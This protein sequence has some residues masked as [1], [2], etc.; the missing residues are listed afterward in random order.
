[1]ISKF[2]RCALLVR[3]LLLSRGGTHSNRRKTMIVRER[4]TKDPITI[5]PDET[6]A[7][8]QAKMES[9]GFRQ[10][11]VIRDDKLV[12]ILTDRDIRQHERQMRITKVRE[13][14]GQDVITVPPKAPLEEAARILLEH[15]IGGLPVVAGE[16]LVGIITITDILRA[17][18]D[19][20]T[21]SAR[22]PA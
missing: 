11:P 6:L 5:G 8:G 14:M 15:K 2:V 3:F 21:S 1:V 19:L 17:F 13:V 10:L 9:G 7:T 20:M 18:V 16:K 12:G 4:M 22:I